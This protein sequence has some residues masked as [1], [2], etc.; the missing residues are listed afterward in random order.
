[1]R[2]P[3]HNTGRYESGQLLQ[4]S[5]E[6]T[7]YPNNTEKQCCGSGMG[8]NLGTTQ[9]IFSRALKQFFG[10]KIFKFFDADPGWREFGSGI[11]KGKKWDQGSG[12]NIPDPQHCRKEQNLAYP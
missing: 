9:I 5:G 3:I 8:K 7:L 12:I 4:T 1:M 6:N 10:V 11:R 2:I